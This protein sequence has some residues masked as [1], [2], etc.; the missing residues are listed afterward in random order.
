M[1]YMSSNDQRGVCLP[2]FSP[3]IRFWCTVSVGKDV[4]VLGHVAEAAVG[5]LEGLLA[6]DLLVA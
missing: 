2:R 3:S 4:A 5:D 6:E 1:R